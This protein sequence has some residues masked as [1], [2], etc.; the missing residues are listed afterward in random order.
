MAGRRSGQPALP[1]PAIEGSLTLRLR[2]KI[3]GFTGLGA[4]STRQALTL[5]TSGDRRRSASS[6]Q[7]VERSNSRC[8]MPSQIITDA[9]RTSANAFGAGVHF[10]VIDSGYVG[11][12]D[13]SN[14]G[15]DLPV[16]A[17]GLAA[18]QVGGATVD[19]H[20]YHVDIAHDI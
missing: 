11:V 9:S 16:T 4:E 3:A 14:S 6:T 12:L 20:E 19:T 18:L 7:L 1:V 5:L 10:H 17:V 15:S 2:P 13:L 8:W